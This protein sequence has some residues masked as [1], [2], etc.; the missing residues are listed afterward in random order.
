[1]PPL[2]QKTG[3]VLCF[4][5][6]NGNFLL[7]WSNV[8][9]AWYVAEAEKDEH[10]SVM[11]AV[12]AAVRPFFNRVPSPLECSTVE[13]NTAPLNYSEIVVV[14]E[15]TASDVEYTRGDRRCIWRTPDEVREDREFETLHAATADVQEHCMGAN[16]VR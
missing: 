4:V 2:E 5:H 1:M 11:Q 9:R 7:C 16:A 6:C 8:R 14:I 10:M 13:R 3:T 15:A 12:Y